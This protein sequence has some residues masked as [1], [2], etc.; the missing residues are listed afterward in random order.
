MIRKFFAA[1]TISI[2]VFFLVPLL[3]L[4]SLVGSF[5]SESNLEQKVLPGTYE[6]VTALFAGQFSRQTK[7]AELFRDRL[8]GVLSSEQ[9]TKFFMLVARPFLATEF[10]QEIDLAPLKEALKEQMPEMIERLP[11][12]DPK[13]N[14]KE[15]FRFCKPKE[16]ASNEI[17][18]TRMADMIQKEIPPRLTL[19]VM[20]NPET[21]RS[22]RA[23]YFVKNYLGF[24]IGVFMLVLLSLVALLIFHPWSS[25]LKWFGSAFAALALLV[26]IFLVSL[27]RLEAVA[28]LFDEFTPAQTQ[29]TKFLIHQPVN[30]LTIYAFFLWAAAVLLF[31]SGI[32]IHSKK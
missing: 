26:T 8:R 6:P 7:D 12:C 32:M 23:A 15:A 14:F 24:I 2:F 21:F 16:I 18:E 10:P 4:R 3:I 11:I 20:E 31:G 22:V 5:L 17:Y 30:L 29:L 27:S 13:E 25:I 28:P 1:I 19:Q 9:Y